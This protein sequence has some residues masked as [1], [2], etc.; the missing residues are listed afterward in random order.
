MPSHDTKGAAARLMALSLFC[1]ALSGCALPVPLRVA[2]WAID[3]I[4]YLATD[5]SVLDHSLSAASGQD[6]SLIRVASGES[7]CRSEN[8]GFKFDDEVDF[9]T[10]G[11]LSGQAPLCDIAKI[12]DDLPKNG[13]LNTCA[14][15]LVDAL[16]TGGALDHCER[17]I[18]YLL[19]RQ[20]I[21]HASV[22]IGIQGVVRQKEYQAKAPAKTKPPAES[23]MLN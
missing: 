5:K 7:A 19:D 23:A 1:V 22:W 2:S 13:K 14:D 3:G 6:C 20:Q 10:Y 9:Q 4:S 16:G 12:S 15:R 17:R 18:T 8:P 21:S 11:N